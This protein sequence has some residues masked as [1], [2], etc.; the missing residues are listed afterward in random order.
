M[1]TKLVLFSAVVKNLESTL[2][3]IDVVVRLLIEDS[4]APGRNS[5]LLRGIIVIRV[6]IIF[7]CRVEV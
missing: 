2:S 7:V 5:S 4:I 1:V 3:V 6:I